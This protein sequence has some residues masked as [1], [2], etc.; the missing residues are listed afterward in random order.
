MAG[1]PK[2][3]DEAVE[4]LSGFPGIGKR[5]AMRMVLH[6]LRRPLAEVDQMANVIKL[7]KSDLGICEIC[8]NISESVHCDICLD[9]GR[10]ETILCVVEDFNDLVA[11]ENTGQY[12]GKYH[13]LGGLISPVNGI[14]P[15]DLNIKNIGNRIDGDE[16]K[17]VIFALNAT[18]EGDTTMFYLSRRLNGKDI[19]VSTVSRGIAVGAELEYTDELTLGR[20]IVNRTPYHT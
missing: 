14:G 8:G 10:N 2:L 15:D 19:K 4:A 17:E 20:S 3:I 13:V 9:R 1:I 18:V 7:L 5:S 6:L 16:V 12:K 11:I